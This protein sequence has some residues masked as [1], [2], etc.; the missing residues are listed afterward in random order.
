[1]SAIPE[2]LSGEYEGFFDPKDSDMLAT[3]IAKSEAKDFREELIRHYSQ[4]LQRFDPR[5]MSELVT[6][7]YL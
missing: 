5:I 1:V 6:E 3:L 2:V 7:S 4:N